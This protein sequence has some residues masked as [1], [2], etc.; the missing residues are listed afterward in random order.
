MTGDIIGR[1]ALAL[2]FERTGV[3]FNQ[4]PKQDRHAVIAVLRAIREPSEAMVGASLEAL[5]C[6]ANL[7]DAG[8][9]APLS[10]YTQ[11]AKDCWQS[12]IDAAMGEE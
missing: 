7:G 3:E 2:A 11:D 4:A 9:C 12:M 8:G 6:L 1:A 10:D 5:A